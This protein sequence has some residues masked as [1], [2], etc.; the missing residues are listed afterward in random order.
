MRTNTYANR[1]MTLEY[2][3]ELTNNQYKRDGVA[4]VQKIPTPVKVVKSYQGGKIS[5]HWEKKSTVDNVGCFKG[6]YI[7]FDAKESEKASFPL[8]NIEQHQINHMK[9]IVENGGIAF[10]VIYMRK[11]NKYYKLDFKQLEL[12]MQQE[13]RKSIPLNYLE[14]HGQEIGCDN[15]GYVLNYLFAERRK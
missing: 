3:I 8:S 1:G 12:F 10:L 6:K 2:L 13:E 14:E 15:N 7:C 11:Y 5:G 9:S 4:V